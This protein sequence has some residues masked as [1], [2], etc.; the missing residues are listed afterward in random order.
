LATARLFLFIVVFA[1][2]TETPPLRR[3]LK[4]RGMIKRPAP[5]ERTAFV[6]TNVRPD[7]HPKPCCGRRGG[8]ELRN[9][10]KEMVAEKGLQGQVKVF[11]SGCLG[12]CEFGPVV[13]IQ[14]EKQLYFQATES[15]AQEIFDELCKDV[16]QP[17]TL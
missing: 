3:P 16:K 5:F 11:Q 10:L 17:D 4:G 7:G 14:P 12:G 1:S 9:R 15:D 13:L 2:A 6:C 8:V